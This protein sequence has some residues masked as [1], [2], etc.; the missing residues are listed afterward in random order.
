MTHHS[1]PSRKKQENASLVGKRR[2]RTGDGEE[3]LDHLYA[4]PDST[5]LLNELL[6]LREDV[7]WL[8][9]TSGWTKLL[10]VKKSL[11]QCIDSCINFRNTILCFA[12]TLRGI[13]ISKLFILSFIFNFCFDNF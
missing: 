6:A 13:K 12:F 11:V 2:R 1:F 10:S 4:L 3:L 8:H 9:R 5:V 7:K